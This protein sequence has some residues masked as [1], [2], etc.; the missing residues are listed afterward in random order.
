MRER[1]AERGERR[2]ER[3]RAERAAGSPLT[4][5]AGA[6]QR[7]QAP[8]V[9]HEPDHERDQHRAD[10][11]RC[12]GRSSDAQS[13]GRRGRGR[14]RASASACI[15]AAHSRAA[16]QVGVDRVEAALDDLRRRLLGRR[17]QRRRERLRPRRWPRRR[18]AI[19]SVAPHCEQLIVSPGGSAAPQAAHCSRLLARRRPV[20]GAAAR[21][22]SR[23]SSARASRATSS[24]LGTER[25]HGQRSSSLPIAPPQLTQSIRPRSRSSLARS[26]RDI[27]R[28]SPFSSRN[29][30][31]DW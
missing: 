24:R 25:Q 14:W 16:R 22:S 15:S 13:S 8:E 5:V 31:N 18:L 23:G 10:R 2:P 20:D 29:W 1:D 4:A 11:V 6:R 3:D 28:S 7:D 17:A 9:P 26:T 27:G 21:S 30:A 12:R 19:A